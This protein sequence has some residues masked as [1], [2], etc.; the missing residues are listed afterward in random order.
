LIRCF[1]I[2]DDIV[3]FNAYSDNVDYYFENKYKHT[4]AR[5]KYIDFND[6]DRFD[7]TVY[8]MTSSSPSSVSYIS[9]NINAGYA[10]TTYEAEC[11]FPKKFKRG[12]PLFFRTDF[13]TSSLFGMHEADPSNPGSTTWFGSDRAHLS[14]YAIRPEE[15]SKNAYFWITSSYL[16]VDLTS[17]LYYDVY[18]NEKW[19]F[20]VKIYNEKYPVAD[21][22]LGSDTGNYILEFQGVNAVLD[23]I[24]NEFKLT[25][26][27]SQAL[28]EGHMSAAKR[29]Y[30]GAHRENFTG[31]LVV[32]VGNTD[33]FSDAKISSVRYWLTKL[34]EDIIR[35]HAKDAKNFGAEDPGANIEAFKHTALN[36]TY[37]PQMKTL[38]LHWDFETVTGSDNGSGLPPTNSSDAQFMVDDVTSGSSVAGNKYGWIGQVA[39]KEHTG[40]GDFFLRNDTDVVQREY[41]YSAE[42][43]LPE[44]LNSDDLVNIRTQDDEIFT[45]DTQPVN[46]YF[47]LEKSMYQT[48]SKEMLR[49]FGTVVAFNNI[50]GEPVNRY[51]QEYSRLKSL[52]TLFFQNINNTPDFERYTKFYKWI[53]DA[54]NQMVKQLMPASANFSSEELTSVIESHILERNK[55]WNKLPTIELKQEPPIGPAKTIGELKYNWKTGH[56]PISLLESDNCDWWLLRAERDT[57]TGNDLNSQRSQILDSNLSALNRRF[58]TIYD[59]GADAVTIIDKDPKTT[60]VVKQINKFGT[61]RYLLIEVGDLP[62]SVDCDDE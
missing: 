46:F 16:G 4:S 30:V 14:V 35:E 62:Q 19:N 17:S 28:G 25:A 36:G 27:I 42:H 26:S 44:I 2:D 58:S 20:A 15:E 38:A 48:I 54:V 29:I 45:R 47:M 61:N 37:V 41:I 1:G 3:S 6:V 13:I 59:L 33:E 60:H 55:Y 8:Q 32:G 23:S 50:V 40:R 56:A 7:S 39:N 21:G 31:S 22:V 18:D 51:K 5:K 24:Q 12:D 43:R 11:L 57:K 34:P 49:F 52:R 9:G 53:D 10:G